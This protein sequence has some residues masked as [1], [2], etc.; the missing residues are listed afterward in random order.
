MRQDLLL[1]ILGAGGEAKP[2]LQ[3]L[4][5][6]ILKVWDLLSLVEPLSNRRKGGGFKLQPPRD[7]SLLK[8]LLVKSRTAG[9]SDCLE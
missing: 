9:L 7:T 6:L 2:V 3:T 5:W 8:V 4:T 1:R